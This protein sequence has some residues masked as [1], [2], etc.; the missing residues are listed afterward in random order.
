MAIE[1]VDRPRFAVRLDVFEGPLDLLLNLIERRELDISVVSLVA[2]TDQFLAYL[3]ANAVDLDEIAAYLVVAA[4]LLLIKSLRLLPPAPAPPAED[5]GG[6]D[7]VDAADAL[8][9]QLREYRR[10]K[11]AAAALREREE[12]GL[13]AWPRRVPPAVEL[14]RHLDI[15][16]PAEGLVRLLLEATRRHVPAEAP[17]QQPRLTV[18]EQ[19]TVIRRLVSRHGTL[20]FRALVG[21]RGGIDAIVATFLAMLELVRQG[22]IAIDQAEP[23]GEI[24]VRRAGG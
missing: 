7:A 12:R 9:H 23:F 1:L 3:D 19:I 17:A 11:A 4:K 22:E 2:V 21:P 15:R 8:A 13:R 24:T 6:I 5:E 16:L 14:S 20:S 18:A 10:F